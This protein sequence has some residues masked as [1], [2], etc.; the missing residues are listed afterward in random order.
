[1]ILRPLH[2]TDEDADAIAVVAAAAFGAS[3]ALPGGGPPEG[4]P[5][6][7]PPCCDGATGT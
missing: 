1:M 6:S 2:D 4:M 7:G 3:D 5:P